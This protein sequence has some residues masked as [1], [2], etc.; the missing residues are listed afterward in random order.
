[1]VRFHESISEFKRMQGHKQQQ[2]NTEKVKAE[3]KD[4]TARVQF[5]KGVNLDLTQKISASS[6]QNLAYH[7]ILSREKKLLKELES[8]QRV[9]QIIALVFLTMAMVLTV[10]LLFCHRKGKKSSTSEPATVSAIDKSTPKK[11]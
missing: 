4:L 8:G 10:T 5:E 6:Q 11:A 3:H 9:W 1:M 7:E 2:L